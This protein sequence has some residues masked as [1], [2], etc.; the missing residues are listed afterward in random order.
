MSA[1]HPLLTHG[2]I[3]KEQVDASPLGRLTISIHSSARCQQ[4]PQ[5]IVDSLSQLLQRVQNECAL[6][7]DP[8]RLILVTADIGQ[9][10]I[11][12]QKALGLPEAGVSQQ[13]EGVV[14]GKHMSWGSTRESARSI[15]IL[16]DYIAAAVAENLPLAVATIVHE[17]GHVHDEFVRGVVHGFPQSQTSPFVNDWPAIRSYLAEMTWCEYA[18]ESLA[19]EYLTRQDL[20]SYADSD[21]EHLTGVH[22]RV[23][24]SIQEYLAGSRDISSLW[25]GALTDLADLFANL[26]R[27]AARLP[28]AETEAERVSRLVAS[29]GQASCW[30]PVLERLLRELQALAEN[31]YNEWESE[32]FG[33]LG[34]VIAL[35]FEAV[36]LFPRFDGG[37]LRIVAR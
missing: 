37:N 10:V 36:G 25:N 28:F 1:V 32:P 33:G 17:L 35:G 27:A 18:A 11:T 24:R 13:P 34:D 14:G 20:E 7:I 19:A 23:R 9:A 5:A 29:D 26:G 12:W 6:Y 16:A 15:I 4:S 2:D 3:V 30:K 31:N 21:P 22:G 8:L